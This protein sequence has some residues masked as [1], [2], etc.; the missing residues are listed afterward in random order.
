MNYEESLKEIEETINHLKV[1]N[2]SIPIIV[3]GEKDVDALRRL[4]IKGKILTI[5]SGKKIVDFCDMIASEYDKVVIL[6]D[7]DKKGGRL[8]NA[9]EQN[10]GGRTKCMTEFRALFAKNM[11]VRDIESIPSYIKHIRIRMEKGKI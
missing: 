5:H 9:I 11:M 6:T 3:E 8:S 2:E 7:W 10:L 4:G 1:L